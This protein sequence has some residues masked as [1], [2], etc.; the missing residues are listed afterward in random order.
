MHLVKACPSDGR[1]RLVVFGGNLQDEASLNRLQRL[2]S[3]LDSAQGP[4][5]RFT[6]KDQDFDSF[7]EVIVVLSGDRLAISH[8][9]LPDCFWPTTG[10]YKM[11]DLHKM[12][13]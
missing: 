12:C 10:K 5:R 1:F 3:F 4:I 11:R 2:A 8:D 6:P 7:I 13:V 9:Q